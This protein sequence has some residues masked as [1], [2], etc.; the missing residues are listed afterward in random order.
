MKIAD[1]TDDY[2]QGYINKAHRLNKA[3]YYK[4]KKIPT[5]ADVYMIMYRDFI[6]DFI[7]RPSTDERFECIAR[8]RKL[9]KPFELNLIVKGELNG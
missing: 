6:Y 9:L 7:E 2:I 4:P 3:M 1:F 5:P 8:I